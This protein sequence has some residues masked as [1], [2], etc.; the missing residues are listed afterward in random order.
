MTFRDVS[1]SVQWLYTCSIGGGLKGLSNSTVKESA[2]ESCKRRIGWCIRRFLISVSHL[3]K[4]L[5]T[6]ISKDSSGRGF[7][8]SF[9]LFTQ[10]AAPARPW[11]RRAPRQERGMWNTSTFIQPHPIFI[12][13]EQGGVQGE[14]LGTTV[15]MICAWFT[16]SPLP[17][18]NHQHHLVSLRLR[19]HFLPHRLLKDW[20]FSLIDSHFPCN[21][22]LFSDQLTQKHT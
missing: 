16:L 7:G 4:Y 17:Q 3:E 19:K 13:F 2:S 21:V 14:R 11:L 20:S 9:P 5:T 15:G 8:C 12:I 1:L 6:H 22:L 18:R 10:A